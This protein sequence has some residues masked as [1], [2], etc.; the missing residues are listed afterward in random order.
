MTDSERIATELMG[1]KHD[2]DGWCVHDDWLID[3][4]DP[5]KHPEHATLVMDKLKKLD[6]ALSVFVS[7]AEDWRS[8]IMTGEGIKFSANAD[9][10]HEALSKAV[11]AFLNERKK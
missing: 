9:V 5:F 8:Q 4:F 7:S 10:W 11:I 1:W 2:G 3:D 6:L